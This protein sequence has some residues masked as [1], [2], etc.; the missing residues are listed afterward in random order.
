MIE[1]NPK[2]NIRSVSCCSCSLLL[3]KIEAIVKVIFEAWDKLLMLAWSGIYR[4]FWGDGGVSKFNEMDDKFKWKPLEGSKKLNEAFFLGSHNGWITKKD[5]WL[6]SQ[7]TW[8]FAEQLAA[9]IRCFEVDMELIND[10]LTICHNP[11]KHFID[12]QKLGKYQ[13]FEKKM[14]ELQGW[15]EEN[16]DEVIILTLDINRDKSIQPQHLNKAL[17]KYKDLI[18]T[19]GDFT[20]EWPTIEEMRKSGKRLVILNPREEEST[21]TFS[22]FNYLLRTQFSCKPEDKG[23]IYLK[24]GDEIQQNDNKKLFMV[25]CTPI[26]SNPFYRAVYGVYRK[27]M[28]WMGWGEELRPSALI[29][30]DYKVESLKKLVNEGAFR[31]DPKMKHRFANILLIDHTHRALQDGIMDWINSVNSSK[32]VEL[33]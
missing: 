10:K 29:D 16:K 17:E 28:H 2:A 1:I 19:E 8:S 6:Y 4:C 15:M 32:D 14:D 27:A 23:M 7:Q 12:V 31:K 30:T 11:P 9:G 18:F 25:Q 22:F 21:Y 26:L 24:K 20:G 3:R 13:S 5:G 33:V